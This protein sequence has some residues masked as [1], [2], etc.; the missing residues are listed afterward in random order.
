MKIIIPILS[1]I[2]FVCVLY[3]FIKTDLRFTAFGLLANNISLQLQLEL[4]CKQ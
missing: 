4:S 1:I 2:G 3:G